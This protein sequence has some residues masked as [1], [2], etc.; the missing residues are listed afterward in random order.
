MPYADILAELGGGGQLWVRVPLPLSRAALPATGVIG[1]RD[2][3]KMG[4]ANHAITIGNF[5]VVVQPFCR[6]P[7]GIFIFQLTDVSLAED[8]FSGMQWSP[9]D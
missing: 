9:S 3:G 4:S 7:T 6:H 8:L 2:I 5:S 1:D